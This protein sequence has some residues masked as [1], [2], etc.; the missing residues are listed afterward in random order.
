MKEQNSIN[1]WWI[2]FHWIEIG[3]LPLYIHIFRFVCV[4]FSTPGIV[5]STISVVMIVGTH[6]HNISVIIKIIKFIL[7]IMMIMRFIFPVSWCC[8]NKPAYQ[9]EYTMPRVWILLMLSNWGCGSLVKRFQGKIYQ[10]RR[11]IHIEYIWISV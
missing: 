9:K 8:L 4:T 3:C 11:E 1:W 5:H 6:T 10:Y 7:M 2:L